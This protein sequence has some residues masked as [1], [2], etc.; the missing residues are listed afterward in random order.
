[1]L[2][3]IKNRQSV[4][5]FLPDKVANEDVQ[6]LINAFQAS[7]CGMGKTA[8]MQGIVVED[9]QLR[10]QIE[11]ASDNACY[12]AP[13]LFVITTQQDSPFSERD[14]SAA[15]ENIMLQATDLGYGSVYIMGGAMALNKHTDLLTQLGVKDG[16][17]VSVIVPVGKA[18]KTPASVDRSHRY[19]V[20]RK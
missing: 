9:P 10:A 11:D 6:Q 5:K 18:A 15:A 14:A 7:P 8:V 17:Q 16:Y 4:R 3:A 1:M 19:E 13:L 2:S 20:T 12:S